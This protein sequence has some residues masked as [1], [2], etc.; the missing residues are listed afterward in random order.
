MMGVP[1]LLLVLCWRRRGRWSDGGESVSK[2][3]S[4][5]TLGAA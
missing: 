3:V 1:D 5:M 4:E 2:Q